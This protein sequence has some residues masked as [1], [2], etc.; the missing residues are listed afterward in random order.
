[1]FGT[2]V[3]FVLAPFPARLPLPPDCTFLAVEV[4]FF[5]RVVRFFA[6]VDVSQLAQ[7]SEG[8]ATF[9]FEVL[10]WSGG[11]SRWLFSVSLRRLVAAY[12][13]SSLR[14]RTG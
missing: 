14:R 6:T 2:Y 1:M 9:S 8:G 10:I 3:V 13:S 5:V 7:S 11:T 4:F 12:V